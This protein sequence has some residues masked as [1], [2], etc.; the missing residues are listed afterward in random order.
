MPCCHMVAVAIN[1]LISCTAPA[2]FSTFY[3]CAM[4]PTLVENS[5]FLCTCLLIFKKLL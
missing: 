5:S 1:G 2:C 4:V 3:Q